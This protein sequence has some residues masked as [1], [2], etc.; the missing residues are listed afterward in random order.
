VALLNIISLA[1]AVRHILVALIMIEGVN[2][3]GVA[4]P[5]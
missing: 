1:C 4:L 3:V 2:G 5:L